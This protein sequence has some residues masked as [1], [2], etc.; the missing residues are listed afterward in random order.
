M[1]RLEA[2]RLRQGD[3]TLEADWDLPEGG[4][5]AVVGPSGGGKSTLMQA[6][7]GFIVPESGRVLLDG[8]DLTGVAPGARGVSMLFQDNNLFPHLSV[9]R[10]VGLGL[11]A[12]RLSAVQRDRVDRVLARVGLEGLGA[13]RPGELSGGQQSRAA[14]ARVLI[15][16]RPLVLLD[17][18]FAALGPGLRAEMAGL[19]RE[20]L[21]AQGRVVLMVT[22]EPRDA[23]AVAESVIFVA[24]G[25][26]EAPME[27]R[28][29]L[30]DPP[31]ALRHYLGGVV[32]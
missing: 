16:D 9:A 20:M 28:A 26:A 13:R 31:E 8:R 3:F 7:A 15:E 23:L 30:G 6:V 4:L 18:P 29:L 21:V 24:A 12:G 2:L 19:V 25:R 22:H 27:T 5:T 32:G 14:L 1:L 11:S 17:E 10:N